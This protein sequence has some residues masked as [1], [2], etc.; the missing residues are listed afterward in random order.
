MRINKLP[1]LLS[2]KQ[3]SE[4]LNCH[5]NTLRLWEQKGLIKAVRFGMRKDRRY[6]KNEILNLL[7]QA[8]FKQDLENI[9]LPSDYDLS[10]IDMTGT[11]YEKISEA[12]VEKYRDFRN[13][14]K[15][16]IEKFDFKKFIKNYNKQIVYF[17]E[18][19]F[20]GCKTVAEKILRIITSPKYRNGS[21]ETI[22]LEK[23]RDDY[24]EKINYWISRNEPINFMLP[25]FPFKVAN[26]LKSSRRDA[27]LAEV[28]SFCKF[29]EINL[30]IKRVYSPGARFVIFHDGHLYYRHFLHAEEDAGRY[31]KTLKKFA[32][33]LEIEKTVVLKDAFGELEKIPEFPK[34]YNIAR[35]E[36][37]N[38]WQKEKSNNEKI[39]K[40]IQSAKQNINLS[41][42]PFKILYRINF[43]EE[44]DLSEAEKKK[45][46]EIKDRSEKCAFEYMVVQ[47]ALEKADFFNR[48]VPNGVRLTV[49]PKEGQIGIYLV[50]RKT[51]LLPWMGTG[52]LKNNGAVSVRYESELLSGGKY[53]PVFIKGEKSPFFYKEAETIYEGADEF[54]KLFDN[55]INGLR[56]GDYYH[57]FAFNSEYLEKDVRDLLSEA[58]RKLEERKIEDKAICRQ[59]ALPRLKKTFAGN[60]NIKIKAVK[61]DIPNGVIIL[62]DRVVN[63]IWGATPSAYEIKTPKIVNNYQK[64]FNE[65]WGRQ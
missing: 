49:H 62:K 58:H 31:F 17:T 36:I 27:D 54:R 7:E 12:A 6:Q 16:V 10:R 24:L 30:Q 42:I 28:G 19:D 43:L 15:E 52:V 33:E 56:E 40:I 8:G 22:N 26:P 5:P 55:I 35:K 25:A 59:E 57:T 18:K 4:L 1:E 65:L 50:K 14:Q 39:Q 34:I 48:M 20:A 21:L 29:N 63:L 46:K 37:A 3:A 23:Y 61:G 13:L 47:H 64:Y 11:Y 60:K 32:A 38:L 53:F 41:D 51:H 9:V 2:I 45:K 44:W